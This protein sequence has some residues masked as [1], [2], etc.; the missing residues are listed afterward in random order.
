M[1]TKQPRYVYSGYWK[2]ACQ[3]AAVIW[4]TERDCEK[5]VYTYHN[6]KPQEVDAMVNQRIAFLNGV[7]A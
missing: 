5:E 7:A 2:M 3:W 1:K 6:R 4:D